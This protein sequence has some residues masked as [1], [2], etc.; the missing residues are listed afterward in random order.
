MM[1]ALDIEAGATKVEPS[2]V[3][4]TL[5]THNLLLSA[6]SCFVLLSDTP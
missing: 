6:A 3:D 4:D 1:V 5:V 2:R